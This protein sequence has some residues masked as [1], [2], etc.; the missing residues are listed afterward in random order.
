MSGK[1][2]GRARDASKNRDIIT[3]VIFLPSTFLSALGTSNGY[4]L[5]KQPIL[6]MDREDWYLDSQI[7][8]IKGFIF[9][10]SIFSAENNDS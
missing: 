2:E 7:K 1:E 9:L 3:D 8:D 4:R 6:W 10:P 5:R